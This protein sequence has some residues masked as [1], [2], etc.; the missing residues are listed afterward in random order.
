MPRLRRHIFAGIA[1]V[2]ASLLAWLAAL[3]LTEALL[4]YHFID[5]LLNGRIPGRWARTAWIAYFVFWI[6]GAV[7][8]PIVVGVMAWCSR[9]PWTTPR[10]FAGR[11]FTVEGHR[12]A[13]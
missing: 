1:W 13:A 9:L 5:L 6:A 11:G 4:R 7:V 12:D 8:I 3:G 2:L 10:E